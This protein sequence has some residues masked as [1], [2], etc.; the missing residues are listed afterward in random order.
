MSDHENN[1]NE[2]IVIENAKEEKNKKSQNDQVGQ[3]TIGERS[4]SS[5]PQIEGE[6]EVVQPSSTSELTTNVEKEKEN[7]ARHQVTITE[8]KKKL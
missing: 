5:G 7:A 2:G 6:K 4:S 3:S 1:A 8:E